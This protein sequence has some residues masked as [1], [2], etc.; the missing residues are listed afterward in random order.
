MNPPK[1]QPNPLQSPPQDEGFEFELTDIE[2]A[3]RTLDSESMSQFDVATVDA[4]DKWKRLRRAKLPTDR[5]LTGQAIDWLLTL[6]PAL[7]PQKLSREYPRIVN[8]L[9]GIWH[10]PEQCKVAFDKLLCSQRKARRGFPV[11]VQQELVA[12]RN[13]MQ[14][15]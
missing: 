12:L 5:A 14:P 11:A 13:W 15:F 3:R 9:A 8:A 1:S 10:E 4:P 6:P 2:D 7:R